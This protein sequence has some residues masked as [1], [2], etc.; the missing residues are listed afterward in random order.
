M[1]AAWVAVLVLAAACG[2]SK[3]AHKPT[4]PIG[5]K[6]TKPGADAGGEKA[7]KGEPEGDAKVDPAVADADTDYDRGI[8]QIDA[9]QPE[10]AIK[11]LEAVLAVYEA[12]L[13]PTDEKIQNALF[14]VSKAYRE[15]EQWEPAEAAA[16]R[17]LDLARRTKDRDDESTALNA[18]GLIFD[19]KG[20]E[21]EA[22]RAYQAAYD[23][24]VAIGHDETVA[25]TRI[26]MRNLASAYTDLEDYR[27]AASVLDRVLTGVNATAPGSLE[28]AKTM[29]ALARAHHDLD[30]D[31]E[32]AKQLYLDGLAIDEAQLDRDDPIILDAAEWLASLY[33]THKDYEHARDEYKKVLEIRER[34]PRND[35]LASAYTDLGVVE[36]KLGDTATSL[37][38]LDL[39]LTIHREN[40]S[41]DNKQIITVLQWVVDARLARKEFAEADKAANE[42]V[43]LAGAVYG[44]T[45][46]DAKAI[47]DELVD[48]YTEHK[49]AKRGK[50]L[51]ARA[52]KLLH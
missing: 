27:S 37:M 4:T 18:L 40:K 5:T 35:D 47:V 24:E 52:A 39:S 48:N 25:D 9:D 11:T 49:Q 1:R 12:K 8:D 21:T 31:Y 30:D 15:A 7:P 44:G 32:R 3:A 10:D 19:A 22:R 6:S 28:A 13:D 50:A 36:D 17:F 43:M 34:G 23:V 20:D 51:R 41:P 38:H 16:R 29:I 45:T 33:W 46:A 2:G 14:F 42:A 26:V